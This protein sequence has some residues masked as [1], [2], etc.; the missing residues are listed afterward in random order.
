MA[1]EL[2]FDIYTTTHI[3]YRDTFHTGQREVCRDRN[4]DQDDQEEACRWQSDSNKDGEGPYPSACGKC[5]RYLSVSEIVN[6]S[7]LAH[8]LDQHTMKRSSYPHPPT[9]ELPTTPA[10]QKSGRRN[11]TEFPSTLNPVTSAPAVTSYG[12]EIPHPSTFRAPLH[13]VNGF[14]VI[15]VGQE[16]RI[17]YDWQV[18]VRLTISFN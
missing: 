17:F 16:V 6:L 1:G 14:Y 3:T 2:Y 18:V 5:A 12:P 10:K 9:A 8:R 15:E 7:P 13:S 11:P 4:R